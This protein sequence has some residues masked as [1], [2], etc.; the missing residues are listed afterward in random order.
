MKK[1]IV[2][3]YMEV[4][5][6]VIRSELN[7]KGYHDCLQIVWSIYMQAKIKIDTCYPYQYL[8]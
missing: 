8:S 4:R 2:D 7:V 3:L 5:F 1:I 6:M